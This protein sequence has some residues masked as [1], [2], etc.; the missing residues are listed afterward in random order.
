MPL[1]LFVVSFTDSTR[2]VL[3]SVTE[4]RDYEHTTTPGTGIPR[5][6][7]VD[8]TWQMSGSFITADYSVSFTCEEDGWQKRNDFSR[9]KIPKKKKKKK[10]NDGRTRD[11]WVN[12]LYCF[13]CS[14]KN[15]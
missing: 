1:S 8:F 14:S 13:I 7:S 11:G 3:K 4:S 5:N 12:L 15:R 6:G 9:K 10:K 2:H